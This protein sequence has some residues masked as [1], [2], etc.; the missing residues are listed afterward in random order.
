MIC[1]TPIYH[2]KILKH[3]SLEEEQGSSL[4]SKM[5]GVPQYNQKTWLKIHN[6]M[7]EFESQP[8]GYLHDP[9]ESETITKIQGA[10]TS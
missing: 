9:F 3:I 6:G 1:C 5:C 2:K 10:K 7:Y 4:H 8:L